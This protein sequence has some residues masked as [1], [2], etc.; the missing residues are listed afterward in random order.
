MDTEKTLDQLG[1]KVRKVVCKV[2]KHTGERVWTVS[3][4]GEREEVE[5][6]MC[7]E[8]DVKYQGNTLVEALEGITN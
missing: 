6:R 5:G 8:P 2:H 3:L 7:A 1:T 4:Y